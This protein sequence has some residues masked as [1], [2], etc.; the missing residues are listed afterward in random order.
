MQGSSM[1]GYVDMNFLFAYQMSDVLVHFVYL[2]AIVG[3]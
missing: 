3:L 1:Q 2:Y